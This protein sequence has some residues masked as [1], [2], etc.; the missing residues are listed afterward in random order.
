MRRHDWVG[1]VGGFWI[2]RCPSLDVGDDGRAVA[3]PGAR[4]LDDYCFAI[5]PI[6]W[7]DSPSGGGDC[8]PD[9]RVDIDTQGRSGACVRFGHCCGHRAVVVVADRFQ[10]GCP[11][12]GAAGV[13]RTGGVAA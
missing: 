7:S 12:G 4:V 1:G 10:W 13:D 5:G 11:S 2:G 6:G 8:A 9:S 3:T